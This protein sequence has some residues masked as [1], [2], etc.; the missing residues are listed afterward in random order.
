MANAQLCLLPIYDQFKEFNLTCR[1]HMHFNN[2]SMNKKLG[3]GE[4][5]DYS[6]I[7]EPCY[8]PFSF[9]QLFY[10]WIFVHLYSCDS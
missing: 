8:C 10:A 5:G 1:D 9:F 2:C 4:A 6:N 7:I 3:E